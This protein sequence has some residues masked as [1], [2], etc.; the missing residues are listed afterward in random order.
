LVLADIIAATPA[1]A[2]THSRTHSPTHSPTHSRTG[3]GTGRSAITLIGDKNYYGRAFEAG[4][5]AAGIDILRPARKGERPH[6]GERFFKPLRQI[7]E[8][9]NDTLTR[10]SFVGGLGG[11]DLRRLGSVAGARG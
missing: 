2:G 8:S 11:A 5:A 6:P 9:I 7:I 4:L 3:P 1:L 10:K